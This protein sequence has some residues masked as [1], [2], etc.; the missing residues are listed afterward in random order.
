MLKAVLLKDQAKSI[1]STWDIVYITL[2]KGNLWDIQSTYCC[3]FPV[4]HLLITY[5]VSYIA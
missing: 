1:N 5:Q 4:L 2:Q 3:A